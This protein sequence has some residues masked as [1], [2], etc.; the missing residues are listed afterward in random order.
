[1]APQSPT[2]P[3]DHPTPAINLSCC[4]ESYEAEPDV[5]YF[6]KPS[7]LC[8]GLIL[9][10]GFLYGN[11]S[12]RKAGEVVVRSCRWVQKTSCVQSHSACYGSLQALYWDVAGAARADRAG[13][14]IWTLITA[15]FLTVFSQMT[16]ADETPNMVNYSALINDSLDRNG[17]DCR[18]DTFSVKEKTRLAIIF[19]IKCNRYSYL[20][21]VEVTCTQTPSE[22][23]F[24][25]GY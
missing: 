8:A 17:A 16:W 18:I 4:A 20:K 10:Q 11:W 24:V 14:M 5:Y 15:L 6:L 21:N 1:M 13:Q 3:Q 19:S 12:F 9:W 22:Q 23:C 7:S 2:Q 25:S